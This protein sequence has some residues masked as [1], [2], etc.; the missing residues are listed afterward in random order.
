MISQLV[1][2]WR[3]G[4]TWRSLVHL[5]LGPLVGAVTFTAVVVL[6]SVSVSL[7]VVLPLAIPVVWLLMTVSHLLAAVERSRVSALLDADL[8]DP[9]PPLAATTWWRRFMERLTARP[10]WLEIAYLLLLLPLGLFTGVVTVIAWSGSL[11]LATLPLYVGALPDGTAHIFSVDVGSGPGALALSAAGLVG[12]VLAAPW[13]TAGMAAINRAAGTWLLSRGPTEQL[14]ERVSEL[15]TSRS[16]AVDSAEAERRRIERDLHD[17]A[18]QRLVALAMELGSAR[19]ELTDASPEVR[20]L[21]DDTHSEVKTVIKELRD[22]VR[23]IHPAILEDRGLDAALSGVVARFPVPVKLDVDVPVRPSPAVESA[24]YFV[25]TEALTNVARHAE[26]TEARVTIARRGDRLVIEVA[27]DGSGGADPGGG[28]GL[29]GLAE[30]AASLGGRMQV[31]SPQ[32]G[33]TTIVVELP[34]GS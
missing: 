10:R 16:A 6:L 23:G 9:V 27:D 22:L 29:R 31:V 19:R 24:A 18:Q 5:S 32:G 4:A 30:R 21:I 20:Q 34:C 12:L 3:T 17:G 25:V 11:V 8:A 7:L 1:S 28:T 2:P 13:L 14:E 26:A 15:E 33:P